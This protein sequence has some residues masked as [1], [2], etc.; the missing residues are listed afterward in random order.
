MLATSRIAG[1]LKKRPAGV[2][3]F[4]QLDVDYPVT[5]VWP[6]TLPNG[7]TKGATSVK[8]RQNFTLAKAGSKLHVTRQSVVATALLAK[9]SLA[10]NRNPLRHV[11]GPRDYP[12]KSQT[13]PIVQLL[14]R[15]DNQGFER[16][17]RHTMQ[18]LSLQTIVVSFIAM[19]SITGALAHG[20]TILL[21]PLSWIVIAA[22]FQ[23]Y[24]RRVEAKHAAE[25]RCQPTASVKLDRY[26]PLDSEEDAHHLVK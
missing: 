5:E 19:W 23:W 15:H 1:N 18:R 12:Q 10:V 11:C 13:Q 20:L 22:C 6:S 21:Y 9:A 16:D 26:A 17:A 2:A 25:P 4:Q 3:V 7:Q 24:H 8:R 14:Q